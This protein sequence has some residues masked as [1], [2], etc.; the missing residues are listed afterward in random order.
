METIPSMVCASSV[1][2]PQVQM[3]QTPIRREVVSA[4]KIKS[5]ANVEIENCK[6][7]NNSAMTITFEDLKIM[8]NI[9]ESSCVDFLS[10]FIWPLN[11]PTPGWSGVMQMTQRGKYSGNL[12]VL[13]YNR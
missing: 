2:F 3:Q 4:E 13:F 11:N 6:L 12:S 8:K 9:D 5:I 10:L 7:S 1:E